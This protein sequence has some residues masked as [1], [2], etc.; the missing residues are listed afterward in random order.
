MK[1]EAPPLQAQPLPTSMGSFDVQHR[2]RC[3]RNKHHYDHTEE[4]VV[5]LSRQYAD[6]IDRA[7]KRFIQPEMAEWYKRLYYYL[8]LAGLD[9]VKR[10]RK[11][12]QVVN[13]NPQF[14]QCHRR[15]DETTNTWQHTIVNLVPS[16]LPSW[17]YVGAQNRIKQHS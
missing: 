17:L 9:M 6:H 11:R 1:L 12:M 10:N 15:G 13:E 5:E 4:E 7:Y 3:H 2:V 16:W 14:M 8:L